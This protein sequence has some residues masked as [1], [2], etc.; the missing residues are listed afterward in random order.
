VLDVLDEIDYRA[1]KP[2]VYGPDSSKREKRRD[3]AR[4]ETPLVYR[5]DLGS[6]VSEQ[7]YELDAVPDRVEEIASDHLGGRSVS[8][9]L[10]GIQIHEPTSS[11]NG[12]PSAMKD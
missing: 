4:I 1:V 7:V 10:D 3:F 2:N 11:Q 9:V 12:I 5:V 6:R 8:T